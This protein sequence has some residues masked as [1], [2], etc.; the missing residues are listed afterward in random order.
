MDKG[1]GNNGEE[2]VQIPKSKKIYSIQN[3]FG[4][5]A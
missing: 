1:W 2:K 3:L 5:K 4:L